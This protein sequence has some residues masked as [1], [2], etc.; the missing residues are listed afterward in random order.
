MIP[1]YFA[2]EYGCDAY[3]QSAYNTCA[4]TTNPSDSGSNVLANTGVTVGI[5]VAVAVVVMAV[6]VVVRFWRRKKSGASASKTA[7]TGR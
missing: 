4:T 7:K 6:A 5:F 2:Q 1:Y 3:G